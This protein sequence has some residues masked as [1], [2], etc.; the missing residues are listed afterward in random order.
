M[1]TNIKWPPHFLN[2]SDATALY[3]F[4]AESI[5]LVVNV[6]VP[7]AVP[8]DAT[9]LISGTAVEKL[10]LIVEQTTL[11]AVSAIFTSTTI[12][13]LTLLVLSPPTVSKECFVRLFVILWFYNLF[14]SQDSDSDHRTS[15]LTRLVAENTTLRKLA[16]SGSSYYKTAVLHG[17]AA[18]A[19]IEDLTV[20]GKLTEEH[21]RIWKLP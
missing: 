1:I 15:E 12:W 17:L 19:S 8:S 14:N 5:A 2:A 9:S 7:F 3:L 18:S 21:D 13:D 10:E 11:A 16:L 20:L 6:V 4:S